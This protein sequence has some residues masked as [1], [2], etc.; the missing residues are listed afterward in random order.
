VI[1]IQLN[2]TASNLQKARKQYQQCGFINPAKI[3]S[4]KKKK[5]KPS[6]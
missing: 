5:K 3:A 1:D 4:S 2:S 6:T